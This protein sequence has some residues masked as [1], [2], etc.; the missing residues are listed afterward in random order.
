[1]ASPI[2]L[3]VAGFTVAAV[4]GCGNPVAPVPRASLIGLPDPPPGLLRCT[5]LPEDSASATIGPAGGS[6]SVGPH[7]LTI[8]AGAL[9]EPVTITAVAPSG[10]V[11]LVRFQPQGLTFTTPASL[12]LGY[13]NCDLLDALVP[14]RVAYTKDALEILEYTPSLDDPGALQVTGQLRHFSDYAVAW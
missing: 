7:T 2:R 12:T 9:A 8:P 14:K 6:L 4:L 1:M 10:R 13:G 11:N 3:W 5:P